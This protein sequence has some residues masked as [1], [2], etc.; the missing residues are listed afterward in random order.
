MA[1]L[2]Y[3]RDRRWLSGS[4]YY[5]CCSRPTSDSCDGSAHR[6]GGLLRAWQVNF[7]F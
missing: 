3:G 1:P 6:G 7:F 5:R 2:A 4:S